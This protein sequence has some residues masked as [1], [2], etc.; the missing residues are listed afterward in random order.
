M[1]SSSSLHL[2][3]WL[4]EQ[5]RRDLLPQRSREEG[6]DIVIETLM[7]RPLRS[8]SEA[9]WTLIA[10]MSAVRIR[11]QKSLSQARMRRKLWPTAAAIIA[12]PGLRRSFWTINFEPDARMTFCGLFS[13][14]H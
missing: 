10:A 3:I 4:I 14:A 11:R 1:N 2:G 9:D 7:S 5:T 12:A 8:W 13:Q 6:N